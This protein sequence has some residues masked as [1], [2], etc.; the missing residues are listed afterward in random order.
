MSDPEA[1]AEVSAYDTP[2]YAYDV[3]LVAELAFVADG[4]AGLR[5]IDVSDRLSPNEIGHYVSEGAEVR[6]VDVDG[7]YAYLAAGYSGLLVVDVSDPRSPRLVRQ[8]ETPRGARTVRLS[9]S[10]AYVGDFERVRV[11]DV[12]KP[13]A[14]REIASYRTP[15]QADGFWVAGDTVY[16]AVYDAG[17]ILLKFVGG[18]ASGVRSGAGPRGAGDVGALGTL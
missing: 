11:F 16:V 6:G 17:L 3:H 14:P 12:S 5:I 13:S 7:R 1:P 15:A 10:L 18:N 2:G 9:G 8:V 4:E